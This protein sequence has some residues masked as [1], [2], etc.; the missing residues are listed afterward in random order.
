MTSGADTYDWIVVGSGFGGSVSALRLAEKGYRVLVIE[1]GRRFG[2]EDFAKTNMEL[3]RWLWSPKAG[4]RGIYQMTFMRHVT[5]L[6]GVGVGGGSLV[7]ANT[8]PKPKRPFFLSKSWAHLADWESELSSHYDTALRMLG[9][10]RYP[11]ETEPDRILKQIAHDIGRP[12]HHHPTD[13]AVFFGQPGVEVDD[14][15]FGGKGPKRVGCTECGACMTGCRVGAKNTLDK[16]YLYLAEQLG[17]RVLPET[18]VSALRP[19]GSGYRVETR[20][21]WKRGEPQVFRA[22]RVVLAGGVMGTIPLL[23]A[24]R[25]DP[26][27]LPNLSARVGR[28]VRTNNESLTAV[29]NANTPHDFSRGVAITSI[30]HTDSESHIE[31]VRYGAGS[32]FFRKLIFPHSTER[33]LL[34]RLGAVAK[35]Y[36]KDPGAWIKA[37]WSG[38]SHQ[39]AI[40]L[41][42]RTLDES[43]TLKLQRGPFGRRLTTELDDPKAAPKANLPEAAALAQRFAEKMD[44]VVSSLFSEALL[45]TPTTAHILGGA[46]MGKDA[47]EGV[48]DA[49]HQVFGYPGLYVI[50]GSAVSANPGVNPSLTIT[51]LAERAMSRIASAARRSS[52]T[53]SDKP[54]PRP[55]ELQA[56]NVAGE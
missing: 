25:D 12:E 45:G 52:D 20:H 19:E 7:Y 11:G 15:Y 23:L 5:I 47:S 3:S 30:L 32:N 43:L 13:V 6:H 22:E 42:M 4:M 37:W 27:G 16:N 34:G 36:V 54:A 35:A 46:C 17:V 38:Q 9:A 53:A 28:S 1:K 10:T 29:G 8:L 55:D 49:D 26:N 39:S 51:A 18:E 50:D 24:M 14:P 44:G 56:S 21:S 31:P 48:I 41:Y 2:R 40:L 33:T